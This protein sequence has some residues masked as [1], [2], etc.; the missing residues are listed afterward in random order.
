MEF[1]SLVALVVLA[2]FGSVVLSLTGNGEAQSAGAML[3]IVKIG[4]GAI[5]ALAYAARG[6]GVP[7]PGTTTTTS[8]SDSKTVTAPLPEPSPRDPRDTSEASRGR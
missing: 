7:A 1:L 3:D 8:T 4:F 6:V 2:G 5:V